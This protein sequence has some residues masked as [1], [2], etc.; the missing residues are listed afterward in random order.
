MEPQVNQ[1]QPIEPQPQ[2]QPSP[3]S[4]KASNKKMT[5]LVT[6]IVC[7]VAAVGV[8]VYF[9]N[10]N[11]IFSPSSSNVDIPVVSI[12]T[13]GFS[14]ATIKIKK[15][16]AI[17]WTN[18]STMPRQLIGEGDNP[19]QYDTDPITTGN[20]FRMTFDTAGTYKYH[21]KT[22]PVAFTGTVVVEQ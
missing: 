22:N 4:G 7:V 14:P 2:S 13:N 6:L 8:I 11:G 15:G 1:S 3:V 20:S 5:L 16:Q 17:E 9:V 10:P 18:S 19:L 21:D 12:T